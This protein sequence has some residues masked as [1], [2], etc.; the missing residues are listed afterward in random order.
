M[1]IINIC[2]TR[3]RQSIYFF[4]C[5]H[6]RHV[7]Y[8]ALGPP[9]TRQTSPFIQPQIQSNPLIDTAETQAADSIPII[10]KN[11]KIL[12]EPCPTTEEAI[13]LTVLQYKR[14]KGKVF[15]T[16]ISNIQQYRLDI[17]RLFDLRLDIGYIQL[18]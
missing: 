15:F 1:K 13:E 14:N 9:R 3:F 6:S 2:K 10:P 11:V 8:I 7:V 5:F 18:Y 17:R 16:K 12:L 4:V